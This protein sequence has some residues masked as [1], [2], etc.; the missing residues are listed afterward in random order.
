[1]S[2]LGLQPREVRNQSD[3]LP[4]EGRQ[5]S[6]ENP[7]KNQASCGILTFIACAGPLCIHA[8]MWNPEVN[9]LY[10]G[11]GLALCMHHEERHIIFQRCARP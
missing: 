3:R 5:D 11:T 8:L 2:D 7:S 9:K 4:A 1:M 6:F 10:S